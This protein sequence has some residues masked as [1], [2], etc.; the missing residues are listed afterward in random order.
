MP[1]SVSYVS[2]SVPYLCLIVRDLYGEPSASIII[3]KIVLV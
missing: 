1:L 2:F 3:R